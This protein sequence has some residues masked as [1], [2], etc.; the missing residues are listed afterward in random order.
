MLSGT[1]ARRLAVL[2]GAFTALGSSAAAALWWQL[3]RR[4][5]PRMMGAVRVEG[6]EGPVEIRRDRWGVPHIR[7]GSRHDLWFG[8]G[9]CHG[10]DRLWQLDLYRRIASGR[11]AEIAGTAGVGTDRFMRTLGLR[12]AAEREAEALPSGLR[13]ELEALCAGINAAAGDRALPVELQLLRLGFEPFTPADSLALTKLLS[14]G[15]STNWERELLRAEMAREL[16]ADLAARL[17]P[18]YPRGNPVVLGPGVAWEGDGLGLAEQ[19]AK[20]RGTIGLTAEATGSNNWAVSA[21][22]SETGGPLLA[23]DPHLPPSMPGI[24]YQVGLYLGDRHC[25]GAS[26]AGLPGVMMGQNNDVAWSFTNAMADVMDL[27][28]ERIDDGTYEFEG[29]RLPVGLIEEDITV[30]GRSEPE[31]LVVRETRHGPIVNDALR[32]DDAEPLALRFAALDFPGITEANLCPLEFASGPD[33]V[34]SIGQHA[35]PVSN[36]VWADRHGSIGYKT[37]GRLPVRRGECPDLPKPGWTGEYEWIGWVPY[38]E[39]PE[40]T[41]P[42]RGFVV[43]A[44]NRIAPEDYPHHI[45]SDYLDGYRARRIEQLIDARPTHDLESF[46]AMQTD[47]LSLPG[48]ETAHRLARLRPRDQ[49]E[50]AAIERL[51]SWD[52][53]MAPEATAA[54][55]YQAFTLRL[56]R[57]V[58]RAAIGDRDLSERWLDRADNG[59]V[60]HV[61]SP[62]RW[63]SHL[64][65]LWEEGDEELVGRP[66]DELALDALR[67]A[68]DDLEGR[69]GHDVRDWRWGEVHPL[70]FPHALGAANPVL[71][72]IFNR[73]LEV[74]G[75]QETVAQVGWDPNDPFT[76][77]WAPCW[78]MVADPARPERSRWQAFTGQSGQVASRHYDDLQVDW[79]EGRTQSMAGEAPWRILELLPAASS[80]PTPGAAESRPRASA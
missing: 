26:L 80:S 24:T 15:L 19:I 38:A 65:K 51:R 44:N 78:R 35:H 14:F 16:G 17:D 13:S 34:E 67:G 39:L 21:A 23:G 62:W 10:Q 22:R 75:G 59:F 68:L 1:L 25:R 45:T 58:T 7:A 61:T 2:G 66:W 56:G 5:L 55:I 33:L 31:R 27:F 57:E 60:A 53:R 28:V 54:T 77:I 76:A 9:F 63:Q 52:G 8:E 43:T 72:R 12:R 69:F 48:L 42:E 30:R 74:G 70:V 11:L 37:V 6:L 29:E 50:R 46:E 4:S 3:F 64:L 36:L 73:R 47:M 41:D 40:L 79:L 20:V 18:G 32:A 71:A 49:R